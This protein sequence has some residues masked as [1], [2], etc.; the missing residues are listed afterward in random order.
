M[1]ALIHVPEWFP[2]AGWKRTARQWGVQQERSVN[3][4]YEWTKAQI[5]QG[6]HETS[7]IASLLG[8]AQ[9]LDLDQHLVDD[10]VKELAVAM[11]VAGPDTIASTLL[12]FVYA[13][14]LFPE[15]QERAQREID[16]VVAIDSLPTIEDRPNLGYVDRLINEVLRWRPIAPLGIPHAC[17]QD[18]VYRGYHI[19]KGAIVIGNTW[20]M[21]RDENTYQ[22]PE[23]F[24]PD[25]YLDPKVPCPPAFGFGRR[26]CPGLQY[27]RASLFVTVA[28]I[29]AVF[30]VTL[31]KDEG[32]HD[33]VPSLES[34]NQVPY[35][36]KPFRLELIPRSK[37]RVDAVCAGR[38]LGTIAS[39]AAGYALW[40]KDS[41]PYP[42]PPS[43]KYY[44]LIGNLL[45]VPTRDEHVGFVEIGKQLNSDI[46]CL[47]VFGTL[48]VVLNSSEDATNLLEKRFSIYSDRV[49]PP[50]IAEPS[51]VNWGKFLSLVGHNERWKKSLRLMHPWLHKKATETFYSSQQLQ[52]RLLLQR[53]QEAS[54]HLNTSEELEAEFYRAVATTLAH[55]IYGY[56]VQSSEDPFVLG[57][58]EATE[59]LAKAAL[60]S[61]FLVNLFPALVHVP[62]WFPGTN[63]KRTAREW[64]VHQEHVVDTAYDESKAQIA[65]GENET[66]IIASLVGHAERLGLESD[67]IDDYVKHIAATLIAGGTD[68]SVGALLVFVLAMLLFPEAQTKAQEEIDAV[69]GLDRLPTMEDRPKLEYVGRLINEVLRWRP[70]VP[71]GVPHACSEDD[72]YQGYRIPKGAI[73]I[74]NIWAINHNPDVYKDP[75]SFNPDRYLDPNV[76]PPPTFG[77]GRR[78]CPGLHYAQ[79]ALFITIAS[80]LATFNI[81]LAKDADG[82]DMVPVAESE[83]SVT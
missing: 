64:R 10:Y 41:S 79:A 53:L 18:D 6:N 45:S 60:P 65:S 13:M 54:G 37:L 15:V 17:S 19:P 22:D 74:G 55:S 49:C 52:A 11:F 80:I 1:P 31:A 27:A 46:F 47:R 61:N 7:I 68:T 75:D 69:V 81:T 30:N 2:G 71:A 26:V 78:I 50:M 42:L 77:F 59:N 25:R 66:S 23:R 51:L 34:A 29:L 62:D 39:V 56:K 40:Y 35:H 8:D 82:N 16:T 21:T 36:P 70:A 4:A 58:R 20:A 43:P 32:G 44:P 76:P 83:N 9:H 73:V 14:L 3:T 28:S 67:E 5:A 63:W 57:F 33:M 48:I 72:V 12:I 24:D 38:G